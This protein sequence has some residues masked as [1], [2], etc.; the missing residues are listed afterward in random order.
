MLPKGRNPS[1]TDC[2][3]IPCYS[4]ESGVNHF[5]C[6][7]KCEHPLIRFCARSATNLAASLN[8]LE[9]FMHMAGRAVFNYQSA[10]EKLAG[11]I[12]SVRQVAAVK[13]YSGSGEAL[14]SCH[15]KPTHAKN[16]LDRAD[17]KLA[18][19]RQ[20]SSIY[21]RRFGIHRLSQSIRLPRARS[22]VR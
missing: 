6:D 9:T 19:R 21:D 22:V 7:F 2:V 1:S 14:H 12:S 17:A 8:L 11:R 13:R 15:C 10:M 16:A 3:V 20:A 5:V 18:R 4:V